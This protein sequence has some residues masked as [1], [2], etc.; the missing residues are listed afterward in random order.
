MGLIKKPHELEVTATIKTL[1]YGQPGG[2]KTTLAESA[3]D[4][5]LVDCDNGAH[6]IKTQHLKDTVQVKL[7]EDIEAL[8][9]KEDL[10]PYKT[11]V[12]DTGGKLL[13]FMAASIIKK[14]PKL[15][16]AGQLTL[17][18]Y[19]RRKYMF[20]NFINTIS[21]M[22]KHIVFVAHEKEEKDG[23]N[24]IVRP[25]MGGSSLG[26]LTKELDLMGY[27]QIIGNKR[28]IS[29]D[30]NEKYYGKNTC[31]LPAVIDIPDATTKPN[32]LLTEIFNQYLN[33]LG[34]RNE[35]IAGYNALLEIIYGTVHEI[36]TVEQINEATTELIGMEHIWDSK[37]VAAQ[38]LK[39][40]A[41]ELDFKYDRE[42]KCYISNKPAEAPKKT[43]GKNKTEK[44]FDNAG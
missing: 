18:G 6:R 2:G 21:L 20:S 22:G 15:G 31:D 24:K 13:D 44:L 34:E 1:I 7:W 42:T 36:K 16:Y 35:T 8:I 43:N 14:E 12:F 23:D 33:R 32:I 9:S 4:P 41:V 28:T 11:L 19:G 30:A 38:A 27:V 5:L 17:Q 26:D 25:E 40:K 3:P 37:L 39:A 29:F 10:T